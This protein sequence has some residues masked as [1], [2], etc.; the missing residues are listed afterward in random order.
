MVA[1]SPRRT[2]A[3]QASGNMKNAITSPFSRSFRLAVDAVA[4]PHRALDVEGL[5][6]VPIL[7]QQRDQEVDRHHDILTALVG[8]HLHVRHSHAEAQ[9]LLQLELY[10][11]LQV[12]HLRLQ[13]VVVRHQRR[14]LARLV[15]TRAEKTR[16]L[17]DQNLRSACAFNCST[18]NVNGCVRVVNVLQSCL[19]KLSRRITGK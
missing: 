12:Q 4:L 8:R 11:L 15:Q 16:D 9:H 7:L 10:L 17:R 6:I 1:T 2:P 13:A 5:H 18:S 19:A 3:T 14:E